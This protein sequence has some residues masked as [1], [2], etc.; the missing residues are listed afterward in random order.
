LGVGY[1]DATKSWALRSLPGMGRV[2]G[3]LRP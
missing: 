2:G 3:F 1:D